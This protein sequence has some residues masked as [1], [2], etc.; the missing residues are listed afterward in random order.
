[1]GRIGTEIAGGNIKW[2]R[3]YGIL[4]GDSSKN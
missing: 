3:C 1:M 2:H 4:Y